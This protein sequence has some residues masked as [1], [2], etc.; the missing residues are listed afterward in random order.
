MATSGTFAWS[1]DVATV[2]EEAY[3]NCDIELRTAYQLNSARTSL[4]MLLTEWVNDG[5]NLWLMDQLTVPLTT[6]TES[7]TLDA[8]YVD[9]IDAVTRDSNNTDTD[10]FRI[11]MSEYLNRPTKSTTGKPVQHTL[12]RNSTGGHTLY[13]WPTAEDNT[14]SFVAWAIRYAEDAGA[15]TN[16]VDT[17][18]RFLPALVFGLAYKLALKNPKEVTP[19]IRA[20]LKNEY[21][22]IYEAAREEDRERASLFIVPGR[23]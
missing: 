20:E 15:Y 10:N 22:R 21:G 23:R 9:L 11:T 7:Y 12:E 19:E 4:D 1:L 14:Y 13:M 2:I 18:R 5:V 3:S 6:G 17:P 16:N 8:K